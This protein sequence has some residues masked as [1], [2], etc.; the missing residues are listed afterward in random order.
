M[1]RLVLLCGALMLLGA[2]AAYA[3][4]LNFTW[5]DATGGCWSDG[6]QVTNKTFACNTNTG[7][8]KM[9][10]SYKCDVDHPNFVGV[11][12]VVDGRT[13]D[14]S[15]VPDWWQLFNT[16]S[17]RPTSLLS[18]YDFTGAP[19]TGCTDPWTGLATGGIAAWQTNLFPPPPPLNVPTTDW[20]RL[21]LAAATPNPAPIV[22]GTESYA[23]YATIL[24]TKTIGS[25]A[26]A[27]CNTAVTF[28]FNQIKVAENTGPVEFMTTPL[29]G[30]NQCLTYNTSSL[31]CSAVP[32]HNRS[33]GQVKS[34]YR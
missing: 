7:S 30:G 32:T 16:G 29:A 17:C 9:C 6:V 10:G 4:G 5:T 34:L 12:I 18:A 1:K 27:G 25:P 3:N 24:F 22:A 23:F 2:S 33:W 15:A 28:A 14:G 26:C 31:P 19:G 13:F 21:K 20:M 8:M 11:E